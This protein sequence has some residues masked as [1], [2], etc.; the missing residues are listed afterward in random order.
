MAKGL[1]V[2]L[3]DTNTLR[4]LLNKQTKEIAGLKATLDKP[5]LKKLRFERT[6]FSALAAN[7]CTNTGITIETP[8]GYTPI[9]VVGVG[10]NGNSKLSY[11]DFNVASNT[12]VTFYTNNTTSSAITPTRLFV[13]VLF[14]YTG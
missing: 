2:D 10:G 3:N 14:M 5:F 12:S 7:T 13:D 4:Y 1:S 6:G 11:C 8:D 9:G